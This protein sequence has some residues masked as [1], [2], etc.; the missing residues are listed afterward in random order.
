VAIGLLATVFEKKRDFA[1]AERCYLRAMELDDNSSV[2]AYN[3]AMFLEEYKGDYDKAEEVYRKA[4]A[5]QP[6]NGR[7]VGDEV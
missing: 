2:R 4:M 6:D 5:I 3:Y 7:L 1:N